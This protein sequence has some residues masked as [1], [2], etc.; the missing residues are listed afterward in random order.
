ME[1][2]VTIVLQALQ[3]FCVYYFLYT[4]LFIPASKI[5][6]EN[7]QIKNELYKNIEYEQQIKNALQQ[8]YNVKNSLC[9]SMLIE[10]I[11]EQ[12]IQTVHQKSMFDSTLYCV[13]KNQLSKE[14]K[15]K[16][17]AFLIDRLSQV[18]KK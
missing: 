6:D 9:K 5:L 3:F 7:E 14:D 18:I 12:A 8:D 16:T 13:E 17:E 15:D 11:P 2:N 4:Y 10:N 1:I